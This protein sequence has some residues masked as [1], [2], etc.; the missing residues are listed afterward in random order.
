MAF[1]S[2]GLPWR[3]SAAMAMLCA[4]GQPIVSVLTY[5]AVAGSAV[6][7]AGLAFAAACMLW[8]VCTDLVPE[9]LEK[10]ALPNTKA[11]ALLFASAAV[12]M[13]TDE[14]AH[15]YAPP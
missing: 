14:I 12:I 8:I 15:L 5:Y 13:C 10:K 9:A 2:R 7:H 4:S 1:M 6:V 11:F 3:T